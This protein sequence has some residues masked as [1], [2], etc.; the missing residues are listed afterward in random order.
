LISKSTVRVR[1]PYPHCSLY[2]Y[3]SISIQFFSD[4]AL[5]FLSAHYSPGNLAESRYPRLSF[6]LESDKLEKVVLSPGRKQ[7]DLG[8]VRLWLTRVIV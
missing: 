4:V 1:L 8:V 2:N 5:H 6:P 3:F 7:W